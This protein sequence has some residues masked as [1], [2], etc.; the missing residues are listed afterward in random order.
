M[1][2][3]YTKKYHCIIRLPTVHQDIP[4]MKQS[5]GWTKVSMGQE[6]CQNQ[7]WVWS[8]QHFEHEETRLERP[9]D[10]KTKR[11]FARI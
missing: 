9:G 10:T 7:E 4:L 5:C 3:Y 2:G 1:A 8:C 11:M 6:H